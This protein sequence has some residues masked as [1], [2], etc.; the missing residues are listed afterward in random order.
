MKGIS[1]QHITAQIAG[2]LPEDEVVGI[3]ASEGMISGASPK[4]RN[5]LHF[6]KVNV[7]N[8]DF[9]KCLDVVFQPDDEVFPPTLHLFLRA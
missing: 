9:V 6:R 8:L 7:N 2:L 3:D 4:E 1:A 5:N